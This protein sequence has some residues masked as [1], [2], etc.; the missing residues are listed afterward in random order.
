[1]KKSILAL[2]ILLST[3]VMADYRIIMSGNGGNIKLP[4]S[5]EPQADFVSH[6][7]TNCGQTGRYGPSL[8]QCQSAYSGD[9]IL[10][11]EYNYGVSQGIQ[12]WT[13]PV[14]GTYRITAKGAQCGGP[15]GGKGASM[16]GEFN[17][18]KDNVLKILVG[19]KGKSHNGDSSGGGGGS[20][21]TLS[22]NNPLL[23][24]GG[25]SGGI[26]GLP[27]DPGVSTEDSSQGRN[28]G[29]QKGG[30]I[31]NGD[32]L[33]T[34]HGSGGSGF[35]G[36]G[37]RGGVDQT[38]KS[39]INGGVGATGFNSEGWG[40]FG[41]GGGY[42]NNASNVAGGGGGY[43]GGHGNLGRDSHKA[44]GGGSFNDG[45]SQMNQSGIRV[46]KIKVMVR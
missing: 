27:G 21:V 45:S 10:N 44:G 12:L 20:F 32:S 28:F 38:A 1:M 39:F 33:D 31:Y 25:G 29:I 5:P 4:E 23:V 19:Q 35:L 11:Q 14:N 34:A 6:T 2:S 26:N 9:E 16:Q 18:S 43:T 8:S 42:H 13:V 24:A 36:D 30:R 7:F 40:G 41:G 15:L 46:A 3:S 22:N 17:L 37:E